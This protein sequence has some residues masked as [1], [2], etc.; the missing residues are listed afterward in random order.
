MGWGCGVELTST[1]ELLELAKIQVLQSSAWL[2]KA[3]RLSPPT[4]SLLSL[5]LSL[6]GSTLAAPLLVHTR[7]ALH[8]HL[9]EGGEALTL[10]FG[11]VEHGLPPSVEHRLERR[12]TG[13]HG[14]AR[15][16]TAQVVLEY[17]LDR[18]SGVVV[19]QPIES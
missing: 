2:Y 9:R 18:L 17:G 4:S 1:T 8:S 11:R 6:P 16:D 13:D 5:P 19:T 3:A 15:P 12:T 10:R 14:F 7:P